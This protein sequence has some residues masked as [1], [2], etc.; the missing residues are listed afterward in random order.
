MRDLERGELVEHF[1]APFDRDGLYGLSRR[2]AVYEEPVRGVA[3]PCVPPA[4][5]CVCAP[6]CVRCGPRD[7]LLEASVEVV[8]D[9]APVL[10]LYALSPAGRALYALPGFLANRGAPVAT[11]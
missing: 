5:P 10:L 8:P 4:G 11:C 6:S 3:G 1:R 7:A 2:V 9:A